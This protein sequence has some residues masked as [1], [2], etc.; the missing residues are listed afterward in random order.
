MQPFSGL[1]S[2]C[3][4]GTAIAQPYP[5][6]FLSCGRK[7]RGQRDPCTLLMRL[8]VFEKRMTVLTKHADV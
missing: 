6:A 8:S 3:K 5:Q 4:E 7:I 2:D 1:V